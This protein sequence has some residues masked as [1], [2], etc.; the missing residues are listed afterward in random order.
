MLSVT[1][2]MLRCWFCKYEPYVETTAEQNGIFF[3]CQ[4]FGADIV[5][6]RR[7]SEVQE[8]DTSSVLA[9]RKRSL[10][11]SLQRETLDRGFRHLRN[12]LYLLSVL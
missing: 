8:I 2:Y 1:F 12:V 3:V 10:L 4:E 5:N 6:L 9:E 7:Y 11:L